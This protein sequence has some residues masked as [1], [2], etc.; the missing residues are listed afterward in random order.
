MSNSGWNL[1]RYGYWFDRHPVDVEF[2]LKEATENVKKVT[3][4][5]KLIYI[6]SSLYL[7]RIVKYGNFSCFT[8][9]QSS[10]PKVVSEKFLPPPFAVFSA[11]FLKI[12][13]EDLHNISFKSTFTVAGTL[14]QTQVQPFFT[15]ELSCESTSFLM[16]VWVIM[17]FRCFLCILFCIAVVIIVARSPEQMPL[18]TTV[19]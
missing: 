5:W 14:E 2:A 16:L 4:D 19:F 11:V 1:E 8:S 3:E 10:Y 6:W 12:R 15:Y 7:L 18:V 13:W 17:V 9:F